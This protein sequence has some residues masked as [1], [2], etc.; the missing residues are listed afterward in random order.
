MVS[1][2]IFLVRIASD[3]E[4]FFMHGDGMAYVCSRLRSQNICS[5][6][7]MYLQAQTVLCLEMA[8]AQGASSFDEA[9]FTKV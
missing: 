7:E 6:V 1:F 8:L 3:C 2:P 5:T 4:P 9:V